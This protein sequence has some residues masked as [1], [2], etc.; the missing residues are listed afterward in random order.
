MENNH[1]VGVVLQ[2]DKSDLAQEELIALY[3]RFN[4]ERGRAGEYWRGHY[5]HLLFSLGKLI[6]RKG[7][8]E[9]YYEWKATLEPSIQLPQPV[10][11]QC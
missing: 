11:Q 10:H 5:E 6:E 2:S 4:D 9:A 1:N 7:P 3:H 8:F